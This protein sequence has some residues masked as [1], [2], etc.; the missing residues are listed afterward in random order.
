MKLLSVRNTIPIVCSLAFV[1]SVTIAP[2]YTNNQNS[3]F[4]HGLARSNYGHLRE[5]FLFSTADPFP[6]FSLII[7]FTNTFS[8]EFLIYIFHAILLVIY[9]DFFG[10]RAKII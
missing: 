2:L 7:Q 6:L 9:F 5:D 8:A 4:F 3:Y 1:L 10:I